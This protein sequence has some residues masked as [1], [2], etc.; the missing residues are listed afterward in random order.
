MVGW[1]VGCHTVYATPAS[2][3][4]ASDTFGFVMQHRHAVN[5]PLS[6]FTGVRSLIVTDNVLPLAHDAATEASHT[7]NTADDWMGCMTCHTAHGASTVMTGWAN[8][9]DPAHDL[10]PDTGTGGIPPTN[11]S[12]LLRL[13]SRGVCEACHGV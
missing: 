8:V 13:N 12:A 11:D 9:A 4:N 7:V 3:Y 2:S 10:R 5:V 6:S 1:C